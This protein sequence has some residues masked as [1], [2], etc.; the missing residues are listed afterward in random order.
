MQ[1]DCKPAL[2][3]NRVSLSP[4][5]QASLFTISNKKKSL[6]SSLLQ[7]CSKLITSP[8]LCFSK[9]LSP[10][11]SSLLSCRVDAAPL[12][13]PSLPLPSAKLLTVSRA[14]HGRCHLKTSYF[15]SLFSLS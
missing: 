14:S 13:S 15:H 1:V 2:K 12:P 3:M 10:L 9:L 6:L 11:R 7:R 5:L 4:P 8:L